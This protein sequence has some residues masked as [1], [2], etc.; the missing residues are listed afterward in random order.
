MSAI[1]SKH[2]KF[3]Q[4]LTEVL[5]TSQ[6]NTLVLNNLSSMFHV[7][8]AKM[9]NTGSV[10][11]PTT[12]TAQFTNSKLPSVD[13]NM[14][15]GAGNEEDTLRKKA[16]KMVRTEGD[17]HVTNLSPEGLMG[18][19]TSVGG[20]SKLGDSKGDVIEGNDSPV[21][22]PDVGGSVGG[23]EIMAATVEVPSPSHVAPEIGGTMSVGKM[24][25]VE[26]R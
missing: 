9:G 1:E 24:Q 20:E 7:M 6:Q 8:M 2:A 13:P 16:R 23:G 14:I 22:V 4:A 5:H 25:G 3:D 19:G 12:P 15:S 26:V 11:E 10:L 17:A 18:G 21:G